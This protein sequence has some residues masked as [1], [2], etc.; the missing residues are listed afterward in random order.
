MRRFWDAKAAFAA[1][2]GRRQPANLHAAAPG[3]GYPYP[4]E[5]AMAPSWFGCGAAPA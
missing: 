5:G 4:E 1:G 3:G 2:F